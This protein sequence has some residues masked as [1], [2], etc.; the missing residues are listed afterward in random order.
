VK[1]GTTY[2]NPIVDHGEARA[3]ALAAFQ[4]LKEAA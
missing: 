4:S 3:R 2:P 1:L